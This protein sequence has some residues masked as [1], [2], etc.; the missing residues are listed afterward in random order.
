MLVESLGKFMKQSD[1]TF[2]DIT[3]GIVTSKE[4]G[5][6]AKKLNEIMNQ[7]VGLKVTDKLKVC[8]ELVQNTNRLDFFMCLTTDEQDEYVWILLDGR[9]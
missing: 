5:V 4:K 8:D 9:L 2:G 6:D 7:I 1:A 3:N